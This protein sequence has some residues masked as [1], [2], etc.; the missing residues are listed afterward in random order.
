MYFR[1]RSKS[2][3]LSSGASVGLALAGLVVLAS[4]PGCEA[5]RRSSTFGD[6]SE[7][8]TNGVGGAGGQAG[9]G[10][11]DSSGTFDPITAGG[12][13]DGCNSGP[14]EDQDGDGWTLNTGDCNDCDE[15]VNPASIEVLTDPDDP[16]AVE[17]DEDCDGEID[18][19]ELCDDGLDIGNTDPM[20]AARALDV[21]HTVADNNFGVVNASYVRANG[22]PASPSLEVGLLD[23]FGVMMP[24]NG[25][26]M[27]AISSGNARSATQANACG[28]LSCSVNGP[29]TPP[30]GFPQDV[31]G[32]SGSSSINDDIGLELTLRAPLNATGYSFDFDF[33]SFEF[34]EW[35]CTSYNDQFIALVEPAPMGSLNGNITF[36]SQTN[37]VSVNIAFFEVCAYDSFYPQFPCA[38]GPAELSATGFD[39]WN[40]AGATSWLVT[41]A[42]VEG[43]EE[44]S[45]R[46]AIWDTGDTAYDSTTLLD[47]FTWIAEAG[48]VTVGTV[49][50]P[51]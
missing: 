9:S 20:M 14:D 42:P 12:S 24:R 23:S 45:I 33:Y 35:V 48:T 5:A 18:E 25:S 3:L 21:C 47:N 7:P 1:N 4:A 10:N 29:G 27:F 13:E 28:S 16:E 22:T 40:N 50:V 46:F 41:T 38:L 8:G 44:F 36:D 6:G 11:D 2:V 43:G 26:A 19:T 31:P 37:P 39:T 30:A 51:E 15:N 32:C 49:P 34:P 17:S